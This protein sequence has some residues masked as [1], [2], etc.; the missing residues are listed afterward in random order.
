MCRARAQILAVVAAA[1]I[2][3]SYLLAWASGSLSDE[4]AE[5]PHN[6][7]T[8][9]IARIGELI[10]IGIATKAWRYYRAS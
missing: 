3:F 2:G 5:H 4:G 6:G 1:V 9:F 8:A 7:A 10:G